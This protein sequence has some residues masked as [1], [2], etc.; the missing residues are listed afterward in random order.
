MTGLGRLA[1]SSIKW[2]DYFD[3]G[4]SCAKTWDDAMKKAGDGNYDSM[5]TDKHYW[6]SSESSASD[7]VWLE[8]YPNSG[9]KLINVEKSLYGSIR[10]VLAF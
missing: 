8:V 3:N 10:P 4:L 9:L 2:G 7:A 6:T 1:E 5:S